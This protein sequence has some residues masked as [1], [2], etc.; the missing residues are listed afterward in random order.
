MKK[1]RLALKIIL[2][3]IVINIL[4]IVGYF[5]YMNKNSKPTKEEVVVVDKIDAFGYMLDNK[6][7]DYYKKVFEELKNVLS[8]EEIDYSEYAKVLSKL[9]ITDL[10]TLSTKVSRSDVGGK[11]FVYGAFQ[12]DFLSITKTSLYNSVKSN[13]YGERVQELPTVSEVKADTVEKITFKYKGET[14]EEAYKVKLTIEYEVDLGYPKNCELILI[15]NENI[16][17]IAKLG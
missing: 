6:K 15:R 13:L 10:Y 14:F 8:N 7:N 2:V 12:K 9:F 3:L 4:V 5:V 16:L 1:L 17:E 11:D